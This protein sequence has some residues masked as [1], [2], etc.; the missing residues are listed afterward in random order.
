MATLTSAPRRAD[1]IRRHN[2]GLVLAHVH[3]DGALTRAALTQRLGMSRSTIGV[4]VSDL[5]ALGLVSAQVPTG[6]E[7]TGRPSHVVGPSDSGPYAV[8]V[9]VD[10]THVCIAAVGIGGRVL[11]RKTVA[12]R[13]HATPRAVVNAVARTLP[14]LAERVPAGAWPIGIGV[15]IP[16]TVVQGG[17][18][19]FAPNLGWRHVPL[20]A[21]LEDALGNGLPISLGNDADLSVLAEHRHGAGRGYEDVV[22]ML[23]RVGVGAGLV[24]GG[25]QMRGH[26]GRAGEIGHTVMNP[27]GRPC[28]CGK[29]GCVETYIGDGALLRGV[30]GASTVADVLAAA[31]AGDPDAVTTVRDVAH[32]LGRV[33]AGVVNVLAPERVIMGGSFAGVLDFSRADVID[34]LAADAIEGATE[35]VV[36]TGP[37]LGDDSAL[38]GA[39]ETVFAPLLEDPLSLLRSASV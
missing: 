18:V 21:M 1:D 30:R 10:V 31:A 25:K 14:L 3:R 2:L 26:D 29:R 27:N 28:Q 32:W 12:L 8:A 37:E 9:D 33:L 4:L 17:T 11:V 19:G 35:Q 23:G 38:V 36:V 20:R 16:G 7:R 24:V 34:A 5:A 15:S 13:L 22:Y 39:A 6:G